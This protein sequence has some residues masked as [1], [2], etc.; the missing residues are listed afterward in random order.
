[1]RVQRPVPHAAAHDGRLIGPFAARRDQADAA[2]EVAGVV[3]FRRRP[4]ENL[5]LEVR[6]VVAVGRE[7]QVLQDEIGQPAKRGRP[8][9]ALDRLDE[10]VP[11]LRLVAIAGSSGVRSSQ[12]R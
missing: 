7:I 2:H 12:T 11:R 4:A 8:A 6:E 1:M 9:R 3:R 5:D 10:R